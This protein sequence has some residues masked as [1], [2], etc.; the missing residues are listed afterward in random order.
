MSGFILVL[1]RG[2]DSTAMANPLKGA[3]EEGK[4]RGDSIGERWVVDEGLNILRAIASAGLVATPL[5]G[6]SC[7]WAGC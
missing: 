3:P 2:G 7:E 1:G 6:S 4:V 5:S